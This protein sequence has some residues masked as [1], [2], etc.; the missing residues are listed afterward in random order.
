LGTIKEDIAQAEDAMKSASRQMD[1]LKV[2]L[3]APSRVSVLE[4]ATVSHTEEDKKRMKMIA[5]GALGSFALVVFGIVLWDHRGRR[6]SRAED[7][8]H[9]LG[10]PVLAELPK[11]PREQIQ[12]ATHWNISEDS[13]VYDEWIESVNAARAM[14]LNAARAESMKVVMVASA[15]EGEGKT[16]LACHLAASLAH[17]FNRVL[18]LDG[19]LRKPSVHWRFQLERGPGLS[20]LLRGEASLPEVVQ[21]PTVKNLYV[22]SAGECDYQAT[23]LL[24][25]DRLTEV[26]AEL[27][28][29]FDFIVVDSSPLL[30]VADPLSLAQQVDAV[31]FSVLREVSRLPA[32]YAAYEKVLMLG[33][34]VLGTVVH[35]MPRRTRGYAYNRSAR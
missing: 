1:A 22:M 11:L 5:G 10:L 2:E 9:G 3:S 26:F 13:Y 35:G 27:K 31:L 15:L 25:R 32:V 20:E 34:R 19:D 29:D 28:K 21:A 4:G 12:D 30:H 16:S 33:V 6:I 24:A 23:Q 8:T 18:L 17:K 7:L 14:I